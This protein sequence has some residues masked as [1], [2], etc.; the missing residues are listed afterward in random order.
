VTSG[1]IQAIKCPFFVR[2]I[3]AYVFQGQIEN[4]FLSFTFSC[5]LYQKSAVPQILS[6][7]INFRFFSIISTAG[8]KFGSVPSSFSV[9]WALDQ[10]KKEETHGR[11]I[12]KRERRREGG[13]G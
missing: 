7:G 9:A 12:A 5:V 4:G 6:E 1:G 3:R 10:V 8:S 2:F 11:K 13:R